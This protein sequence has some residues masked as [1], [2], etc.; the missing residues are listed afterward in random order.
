MTEAE[1]GREDPARELPAT[2]VAETTAPLDVDTLPVKL[3]FVAG[4]TEV[5][6]RQLQDM[7]PGYVFDLREPVDGHVEVR[8]NGRPVA[9]GELVEIAGRVGVRILE[10]HLPPAV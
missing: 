7:A 2:P 6:L 9:R 4:E 3:V 5:P 8:A 1:S 10:C